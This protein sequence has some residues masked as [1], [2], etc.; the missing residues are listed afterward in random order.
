MFILGLYAFQTQD[1]TAILQASFFSIFTLL[2]CF[3]NSQSSDMPVF[4]N[5]WKAPLSPELSQGCHRWSKNCQSVAD[6]EICSCFH[7]SSH[8][9]VLEAPGQVCEALYFLLYDTCGGVM[10][11]VLGHSRRRGSESREWFEGFLKIL[12]T[13]LYGRNRNY[14]LV[15]IYYY[16]CSKFPLHPPIQLSYSISIQLWKKL[17]I[18]KS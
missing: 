14:I 1:I 15:L 6:L 12:N 10:R 11:A 2:L 7:S 5:H 17:V 4:C 3:G 8:T 16:S 13:F 18:K 9:Q